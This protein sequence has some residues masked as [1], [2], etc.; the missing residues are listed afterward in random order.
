[1]TTLTMIWN[2]CWSDGMRDFN[3]H[4]MKVTEPSK[5]SRHALVSRFIYDFY[6]L[7]HSAIH[8]PAGS[9]GS[10]AGCG[11]VYFAPDIRNR[12]LVLHQAATE[13]VACGLSGAGAPDR[14]GAA[15]S[16]AAWPTLAIGSA[17][18]FGCP[19]PGSIGNSHG[20]PIRLRVAAHWPI[21]DSLGLVGQW[22]T[23]GRWRRGGRHVDPGPRLSNSSDDRSTRLFGGA[24]GHPPT[25]SS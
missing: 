3:R 21:T 16:D 2:D 18:G 5:V 20:Y 11:L 19:C 6:K 4:T 14:P 15:I 12:E 9:P 25:C 7:T 24:A 10:G 1:M 22:S 13:I 8:A 17:A 23:F